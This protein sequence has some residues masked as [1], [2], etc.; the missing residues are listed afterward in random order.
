MRLSSAV[1]SGLRGRRGKVKNRGF[2]L[3]DSSSLSLSSCIILA[4]SLNLVEA[5]FPHL[6]QMKAK[7]LYQG[8]Q[9]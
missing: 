4:K 6:F 8:R 2:P 1:A 5:W 3:A 7:R 9:L